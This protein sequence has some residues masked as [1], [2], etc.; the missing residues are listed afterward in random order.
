MS[1]QQV[2]ALVNAVKALSKRRWPR[3]DKRRCWCSAWDRTK[4]S[5]GCEALWQS[6]RALDPE[7]SK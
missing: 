7:V 5:P 2:H 1:D 4:H 6:I 3:G